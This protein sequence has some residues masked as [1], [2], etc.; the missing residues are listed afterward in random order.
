VYKAENITE[1]PLDSLA[2]ALF[3]DEFNGENSMPPSIRRML[4]ASALH[5][6][7]KLRD[8]NM[9]QRGYRPEIYNEDNFPQMHDVSMYKADE[10]QQN[11]KFEMT[12][13]EHQCW[14]VFRLTDGWIPADAYHALGYGRLYED[15]HREHRQFAGKM[16]AACVESS[17]LSG[18][19]TKLYGSP[20]Y[21]T[22]Y[23]RK[24]AAK[25]CEAIKSVYPETEFAA[26]IDMDFDD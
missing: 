10:I 20:S 5:L 21:F 19:G 2:E 18:T 4:R 16:S 6:K 22:E 7:Y 14:V 3:P 13:L 9:I 17:A 11:F 1:N 26:L 24:T 23:D 12:A 15:G 25:T 8:M